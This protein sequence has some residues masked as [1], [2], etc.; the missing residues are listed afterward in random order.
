[1][2]RS[3]RGEYVDECRP[4]TYASISA[5]SL[6]PERITLRDPSMMAHVHVDFTECG[7][8]LTDRPL[9][10]QISAFVG[11]TGDASIP[12]PGDGGGSSARVIPLT[13]VGPPAAGATSIDVMIANPFFANVPAD[14][15]ITLQFVPVVDGCA[16]TL[17]STTYRTGMVLVTP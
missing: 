12:E 14:T 16:G 4:F 6:S 10:V 3:C 5:A 7:M 13:T 11:G 15:N 8:V 17:F 2:T 1:M 9:T